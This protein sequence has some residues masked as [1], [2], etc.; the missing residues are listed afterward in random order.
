MAFDTTSGQFYTLVRGE[1]LPNMDFIPIIPRPE[2]DIAFS[3][4]GH[5]VAYENDTSTRDIVIWDLHVGR[6]VFVFEYGNNPLQASQPVWSYDSRYMALAL[7]D[8]TE[9]QLTLF[10]VTTLRQ[11]Q[12]TDFFS[13]FDEYSLPWRSIQAIMWS[14]NSRY[15]AF[16]G[17]FTDIHILDVYTM[18]LIDTCIRG[19]LFFW[20][21]DDNYLIFTAEGGI[22]MLDVEHNEWYRIPNTIYNG[23]WVYFPSGWSPL[24]VEA[25]LTRLDGSN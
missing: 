11:T 22:H 18:T 3:R 20:L 9:M 16:R 8:G 21:P 24:S 7:F 19:G 4:D 2:F 14:P 10:D 25:L 23:D 12:I 5:Y 1:Q 15:I 13:G 6:E 17:T